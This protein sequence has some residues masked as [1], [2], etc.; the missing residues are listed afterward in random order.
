MGVMLNPD[1]CSL[2]TRVLRDNPY[3]ILFVTSQL[4]PRELK[5]AHGLRQCGWSVGLVYYKWTPFD[6][7][8]FFDFAIEVSS[9]L[10]AHATAKQLAPR[11]THVFSGAIDD[12][13]MLFCRDKPS[14][15][16]IDLNDV[17]AP[18]LFDYCHERFEPTREAL[19]LADGFC[20]RD[21][22]VKSAERNDGFQLPRHMLLFP[23]YCWVAEPPPAGNI[24]ADEVHIVSVGTFSLETQG[25]YDSCYLRLTNLLIEQQI[26]FHI[27]PHWAY[28]RDH[29]GSPNINFER[30]FAD[31]IALG[32]SNPYLHLHD[33]L[34]LDQLAQVLPQY[35]FGII[36]GGC[37]ELGQKLGFYHKPYLDTCYSGRISDYLEAR[38]PVLVNDEVKFDYWLL[39]RYG[40]CVDLK[41]VLQ[42][43]FKQQLIDLKN[44]SCQK[45]IMAQAVV[46]LSVRSNSPRLAQFYERILQ[47]PS[48]APSCVAIAKKPV[49]VTEKIATIAAASLPIHSPSS[50][51]SVASMRMQRLMFELKKGIRWASPRIAKIVLPYRAMRI[52]QVR[53]HNALIELEA[54][55]QTFAK[56]QYKIDALIAS[57]NS[58]Q[59]KLQQ[60]EQAKQDALASHQVTQAQ[61]G[62]IR[63]INEKLLQQITELASEALGAK[64]QITR[65]QAEL[66]EAARARESLLASLENIERVRE[67]LTHHRVVLEAERTASIAQINQQLKDI[68]A[69]NNRSSSFERAVAEL[70]VQIEGLEMLRNEQ[71]YRVDALEQDKEK[72]LVFWRETVAAHESTNQGLIET[73]R[74][75]Q[76]VSTQLA[77]SEQA[78]LELGARFAELESGRE[79]MQLELTNL[80][81]SKAMLE[82]RLTM[83]DQVLSRLRAHLAALTEDKT[84]SHQQIAKLEQASMTLQKRLAAAEQDGA[85]K[86]ATLVEQPARLTGLHQQVATFEQT[87]STMN[88]QLAESEQSRADL[89]AAR[90]TLQQELQRIADTPE[91]EQFVTS[92]NRMTGKI[93]DAVHAKDAD[94]VIDAAPKLLIACMPKSGSTWLTSTL[95]QQLNVPSRR[96]YLEADRNEQEIDPIALFQSWGN[97]TL[98]VQQHIRYARVSMQLLKAFS[99]KVVVLT[100]RLDDIVVSLRDHIEHESPE[101]SM[102]YI[103]TDWYVKKTATER[104]DFLIDYAM[105]WYLNFYLGWQRGAQLYP[106]QILQIPYEELIENAAACVVRIADFYGMASESLSLADL[107]KRVGTRFNQGRIGRGREELSPAQQRRLYRLAAHYPDHDFSLIGV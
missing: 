75:R 105:P 76:E 95:E 53:L 97:R 24:P 63:A 98:F 2:A 99:T 96:C 34:P 67:E 90:D 52:F 23:E 94:F 5:M 93:A 65:F 51:I 40:V 36:S 6:P 64:Q 86:V 100:R 87:G 48:G 70:R 13:I 101:C 68:E 72:L 104:I 83:Q 60:E 11:I 14:P 41:G 45:E 47:L 17:F 84:A 57:E 46:A 50:P 89:L 54:N 18:S 29:S 32:K 15:V 73:I 91:S 33:S 85:N 81:R 58:L 106:N 92:A 77:D 21:L 66:I 102:F 71:K 27:Y 3:S 20:A 78:R 62:E 25:M 61:L 79:Q 19:A 69:A 1:D 49:A 42:P 28:R 59:Q 9:A 44:D 74:S 43:G 38:L 10:E 56:L 22:Q 30:D 35:D 39:K 37:P 7:I 107:D 16:V 8:T 55:R 12:F 88:T 103:E 82:E 80:T 26:H 31:F 4:R